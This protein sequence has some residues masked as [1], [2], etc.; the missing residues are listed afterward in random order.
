MSDILL[1]ASL[2]NGLEGERPEAITIAQ[3]RVDAPKVVGICVD[4]RDNRELGRMELLVG[5]A[6]RGR[7]EAGMMA[8]FPPGPLDGVFPW[9]GEQGRC[10]VWSGRY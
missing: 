3:V 10:L 9:N 4:S 5:C 7:E 1:L 2:E 6:G 8:E